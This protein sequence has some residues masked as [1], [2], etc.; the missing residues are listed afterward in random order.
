MFVWDVKTHGH[1]FRERSLLTLAFIYD[2]RARHSRFVRAHFLQFRNQ[3]E[4]NFLF[5]ETRL[6][7]SYASSLREYYMPLA[8]LSLG[9]K[10]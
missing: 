10:F 1:N 4:M 8:F 2:S 5:F 9:K 7:R 6:Q 3:F